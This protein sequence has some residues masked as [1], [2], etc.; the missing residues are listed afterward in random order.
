MFMRACGQAS[1]RGSATLPKAKC[2]GVRVTQDEA[3]K[4]R[5]FIERVVISRFMTAGLKNPVREITEGR[6]SAA[7]TPA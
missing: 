7:E 4:V 1:W 5:R 3:D 2:V 6:G